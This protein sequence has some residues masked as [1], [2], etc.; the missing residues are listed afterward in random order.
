[1]MHLM[2]VIKFQNGSI[3]FAMEQMGLYV[4][5]KHNGFIVD[6]QLV[7]AS[8]ENVQTIEAIITEY[9]RHFELEN[10][11]DDYLQIWWYR[12]EKVG[13][14]IRKNG[15]FVE[16]LFNPAKNCYKQLSLAWGYFSVSALVAWCSNSLEQYFAT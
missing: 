14:T 12:K 3:V 11:V 8:L 7:Y 13:F 15:Y 10:L 16:V 4:T 1:M 9:E 2:R 5:V 6:G